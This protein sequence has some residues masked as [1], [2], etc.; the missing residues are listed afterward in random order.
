M[1]ALFLLAYSSALPISLR[2]SGV[3]YVSV[4]IGVLVVTR[5]MLKWFRTQQKML[6]VTTWNDAALFYFIFIPSFS[7]MFICGYSFDSFFVAGSFATKLLVV[8][9]MGASISG[10]ATTIFVVM[11]ELRLFRFGEGVGTAPAPDDLDHM[12]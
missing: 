4:S 8:L 10:A 11:H 7:W 3:F 6:H 9:L 12:G 1:T 2:I 5:L